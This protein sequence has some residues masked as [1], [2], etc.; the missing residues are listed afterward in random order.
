MWAFEDIS[1]NISYS[2]HI[3][4]AQVGRH[5]NMHRHSTHTISFQG[6]FALIYFSFYLCFLLRLNPSAAETPFFSSH[7]K[8]QQRGNKTLKWQRE[9]KRERDRE[10]EKERGTKEMDSNYD[11]CGGK[12]MT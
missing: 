4:T 5:I 8:Q 11:Q 2:R 7:I 3:K 12:T 9:R 10:T 6:H 1:L